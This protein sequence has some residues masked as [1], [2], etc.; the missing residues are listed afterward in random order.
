MPQKIKK[1]VSGTLAVVIAATAMGPLFSI[2]SYAK[3]FDYIESLKT[4]LY[5]RTYDIIELVP[6]AKQSAMSYLAAGNEPLD[7]Y[8]KDAATVEGW[9]KADR[10]S[11]MNSVYSDL[12]NKGI[13]G[14][15][16]TG[17]PLTKGDGYK[18]YFPWEV[19][20]VVQ[21]AG[22]DNEIKKYYY[23]GDL[24]NGVPN[25]G[26]KELKEM[27]LASLDDS[28]VRG[29]FEQAGEG[30]KGDYKLNASYS[31]VKSLF[32]YNA[33][34][35]KFN[36]TSG[37]LYTL[38]TRLKNYLA[39]S[40]DSLSFD[41]DNQSITVKSG[42]R[43]LG[44]SLPLTTKY[45]TWSGLL[46][47]VEKNKEYELSFNV[48]V[49]GG[50]F[51]VGI[52]EAATSGSITV[53]N[54]RAAYE[55]EDDTSIDATNSGTYTIRFTTGNSSDY[56]NQ[57]VYIQVSFGVNSE[58]TTATFSDIYVGE[59]RG[60]A[61]DADRFFYAPETYTDTANDF[62][63]NLTFTPL[64]QEDWENPDYDFNGVAI[65]E[66]NNAKRTEI[67]GSNPVKYQWTDGNGIFTCIGVAGV[68][69]AE[70]LDLDYDKAM[71]G[72][73]YT[74]KINSN[75]GYV[76]DPND[77]QG[78]VIPIQ[79]VTETRDEYHTYR[80][81]VKRESGT[82]NLAFKPSASGFF[83]ALDKTYTYIKDGGD[84]VFVPDSS[85]SDTI[86]VY[87]QKA[88]FA[89]YVTNNDLFKYGA[90]DY[91]S[92]D[93]FSVS[94]LKATPELVSANEDYYSGLV[95]T[96]DMIVISAGTGTSVNSSIDS[97]AFTSDIT[98]EMKEAFLEAAS[99]TY[100][101]PVV[102]DARLVN[103]AF[104][105]RISP[106]TCPIL[107]SLV[108]ELIDR[109]TEQ[110]GIS[111]LGGGV[112]ANIYAF[113]PSNIGGTAASIAT[114]EMYSTI[115]NSNTQASPYYDVRYQINYENRIRGSANELP[116]SAVNEASCLRCIINYKG[117]RIMG[118]LKHLRVLDIEPYTNDPKTSYYYPKSD[119]TVANASYIDEYIIGT[120]WLPAGF[121]MD[122][123]G[124]NV[125]ITSSNAKDYITLTRMSTAEL[126][127]TG[128]QIIENYD[129]V[130]IGASVGN[131]EKQ[132]TNRGGTATQIEYNDDSS[133]FK[134]RIYSGI[135]DTYTVGNINYNG[136][137]LGD[138]V[139]GAVEGNT[140]AGLLSVDYKSILGKNSVFK[141]W[142][143]EPD[144][145][146]GLRTTGNDITRDVMKQLQDFADAGFPIVFA[147]ELVGTKP[148]ESYQY[149]VTIDAKTIFRATEWDNGV[150]THF[151]EYYTTGIAGIK[152]WNKDKASSGTDSVYYTF[153][154]ATIN[155]EIPVGL[156]PKFNWYYR[157]LSDSNVKG[158]MDL[159]EE[160]I[161]HDKFLNSDQTAR[162]WYG[163]VGDVN[164]QWG[165]RDNNGDGFYTG[166][167]MPGNESYQT[168]PGEYAYYCEVSFVK[169][170]TATLSSAVKKV[171]IDDGLTLKSNEITYSASNQSFTISGYRGGKNK[172]SYVNVS[173]DMTLKNVYFS[174]NHWRCKQKLDVN[175]GDCT[176]GGSGVAGTVTHPSGSYKTAKTGGCDN[177][178]LGFEFDI[179]NTHFWTTVGTANVF[180]DSGC[181]GNYT[182]SES[183]DVRIVNSV[184]SR[185]YRADGLYDTRLKEG[186]VFNSRDE[187]FSDGIITVEN[188]GIAFVNDTAVD[189]TTF[190]YQFMSNVYNKV[191]YT[192][193]ELSSKMYQDAVHMGNSA[194][195]ENG[196]FIE[197]YRNRDTWDNIYVKSGFTKDEVKEDLKERL[198]SVQAPDLEVEEE[199]LVKYPDS[200]PDRN[201]EINFAIYNDK[202]EVGA[203]Y[204]VRLFIDGNHD[205][206]FSSYEETDPTYLRLNKG[207]AEPIQFDRTD[208]RH[209]NDYYQVTSSVSS[210]NPYNEYTLQKVLPSSYVGIIP[211]KLEVYDVNNEKLHDSYLGYA[212]RKAGQDEGTII[213]AVQV[214]PA[215]QWTNSVAKRYNAVN[216][217]IADYDNPAIRGIWRPGEDYHIENVNANEAPFDSETIRAAKNGNA[218]VGSLFL[219]TGA[220]SSGTIYKDDPNISGDKEN[221]AWYLRDS[222]TT[223]D[224]TNRSNFIYQ[225][226]AA[227]FK[228]DAFYQLCLEDES[229][230]DRTVYYEDLM[231][232]IDAD[233]DTSDF[234]QD[235]KE[236]LGERFSQFSK[237]RIKYRTHVEFWVNPSGSKVQKVENGKPVYDYFGNP[238]MT[239]EQYDFELDIALTDIYELNF[240]WY[241]DMED[242][243]DEAD[244]LSQFDMLILGFGDSYGKLARQ[245]R[246]GINLAAATLGFNL[247]AATAIRKYVDSGKPVLFCHDTTNGNV[248]FIDYYALNVVSW[249]ANVVDQVEEFWNTTVKETAV[250]V[251]YWIRNA[252]RTFVGKDPVEIPK[253]TNAQEDELNNQIADNRTRDG[254]Y[255]NLI[256]RYPLKLDRYGI[257]YEICR[258]LDEKDS[259]G[260]TYWEKDDFRSG[261]GFSY[262]LGQPY[263]SAEYPDPDNRNKKGIISEAEMLAH[264]FTVAYEPGSAL[265]RT[266]TR[267]DEIVRY[268]TYTGSE[269]GGTMWINGEE[270][271]VTFTGQQVQA[272]YIYDVQGFTKWTIARY[273]SNSIIN[274]SSL[275]DENYY[276]P[277][278]VPGSVKTAHRDPYYTS[279]ITQVSKGSITS[280]PYDINTSKFGGTTD[281]IDYLGNVKKKGS[282]TLKDGKI[283]IM[284]TH[285]QYYQ[286]NLNDGDT[287][288]WYCLADPSAAHTGSDVWEGQTC[289][290][291]LPNDCVN[292]YYIYTSGN[293]TYTGAGHANLFTVEEA[294]L[295]INTL[296]GAYRA[297]K[298]KPEVYFRDA[299]N[300]LNIEYQMLTSNS[301]S[302]VGSDVVID[303]A[304]TGVKI[305][306]PNINNGGSSGLKVKFYKDKD[307]TQPLTEIVLRTE[308][309]GGVLGG[310]TMNY[311]ADGYPVTSDV[312]YYFEVPNEVKNALK[313]SESYTV[314]AQ[315]TVSGEASSVAT[316]EYRR[317]GLAS[318]S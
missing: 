256:L 230:L 93:N 217:L 155:G 65:Y 163:T 309:N 145:N 274:D 300:K 33:F 104:A 277:I 32:S 51:Y 59:P 60:Y 251:W 43:V 203:K 297:A 50:E 72:G 132:A 2:A 15:S 197:A 180:S 38:S 6:Q 183:D 12:A 77:E 8:A 187:H 137:N 46:M 316:I 103:P 34:Y 306:D 96:S 315:A 263:V 170:P 244:F 254:Y 9:K 269:D 113:N 182:A 152:S 62:W 75:L 245:N 82:S 99:S 220:G 127:G 138:M 275:T 16:G 239:Y 184:T 317:L 146:F 238:V 174:G 207:S 173:P 5:D 199:L 73:Y 85:A 17:Y 193:T 53:T 226:T 267:E 63:Y 134:N 86:T 213:R 237:D 224:I 289:Y 168:T 310:G 10:A 255:N 1:A 221:E 90:L 196:D 181:T 189:N 252:V 294:K 273:I 318:L 157:K 83:K 218:Y 55:T 250:K 225:Y 122:S 88:Y 102:V 29:R 151:N 202:N 246:A 243:E 116:N 219:G 242:A 307:L 148:V 143:I 280:Y 296:V 286:I 14:T 71:E 257:T 140:L 81:E 299:D 49:S 166:L 188:N 268:R 185:T 160:P 42:N 47:R 80:A 125:T 258:Q 56:I 87:T 121:F 210:G 36:A 95:C 216:N 195:K 131:L 31:P 141:T 171:F 191:E 45:T 120:Q 302:E 67:P 227:D 149:T 209:D 234:G 313:T 37:D 35:D 39:T 129:L 194:E 176:H 135:G 150:Q 223:K 61:Q 107:Y 172:N 279:A 94:I 100:K 233:V 215:D 57:K 271:N 20:E 284:P 69:S 211:W 261:H 130:Y 292:S 169:D 123:N 312:T 105:N 266:N 198:N 70:S 305:V 3:S 311:A 288:V 304:V 114:K 247:Y 18:E 109:D 298:E 314:Y 133:Y 4:S 26:A 167:A 190:L 212:Y 24:T 52:F 54:P 270:K 192:A 282:E 111:I 177:G 272:D 128:A 295:F 164:Y 201:L 74:A 283:R 285:E 23:S 260:K 139:K 153:L 64:T 112:S 115:S 76:Q 147:D 97:T 68:D 44:A 66:E 175:Y 162:Q 41:S 30:V 48:D 98:Q 78:R 240:C 262:L 79:P 144:Y 290:D 158:Q 248:N 110:F 228:N 108:T 293:V 179:N 106:E 92:D 291:L 7:N 200:L 154:R 25:S 229:K 214:L 287:T 101:I 253:P 89:N 124:N 159:G 236:K 205:A 58:K 186:D 27:E 84:Y 142:Y 241:K 136:S 204:F 22:L 28:T 206:V 119:N 259:S 126:N 178:W 11:Y 118:N 19:T 21:N 276:M 91:D 265:R 156:T 13:I 40:N 222:S 231:G 232:E 308:N 161:G 278:T 303:K 264:G 208:S 301:R 249:F 165:Y 235:L 281:Y 117:R